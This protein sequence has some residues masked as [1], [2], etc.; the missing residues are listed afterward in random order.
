MRVSDVKTFIVHPGPTLYRKNLLFVKVETDDGLHGWG[1]CYTQA[2]RDRSIEIF[3]QEMK[4]YLV[5]RSP[6]NI[7]HF[8]QV[9]YVDFAGRRGSLEFYSAL[10]G[11][12][13]ALWDILG[14]ALGQPVYNLLGGAARDRIRVYANGWAHGDDPPDEVARRASALV[15]RGFSAMKWDIFPGPWRVRLSA[16]DE[17]AA[18]ESVRAVR[19]AVGPD[20]DLLIECHR[21][22]APAP[23]IRVA[24][25]I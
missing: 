18:V 12:E 3:L 2:D 13:M 15:A 6:F 10:S 17:R 11:L 25:Q 20:V 14:K 24:Q 4:R 16:A 19:K 23:A 22:L 1:E 21:R 5:G 7:K 9:M 8:T